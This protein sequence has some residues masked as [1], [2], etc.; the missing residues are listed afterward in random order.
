MCPALS[1][2]WCLEISGNRSLVFVVLM[3]LSTRPV[4]CVDHRRQQGL[5]AAFLL[6]PE[7]FLAFGGV[8]D[9]G[10]IFSRCWL[11]S[12]LVCSLLPVCWVGIPPPPPSSGIDSDGLAEQELLG[13]NISRAYGGAPMRQRA[14]LKSQDGGRRN[15]RNVFAEPTAVVGLYIQQYVATLEG[16]SSPK[17]E[18]GGRVVEEYKCV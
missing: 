14:A 10:G 6:A 3:L 2:A 4:L 13:A 15:M 12:T 18:G 7:S 16:G 11:F 17:G 1:S 5:F 8:G 9:A